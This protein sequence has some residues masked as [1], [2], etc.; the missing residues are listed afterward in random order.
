MNAFNEENMGASAQ[1][2]EVIGKVKTAACERCSQ[3]K[4]LVVRNPVP[5]VLGALVF[6]AAVGYL[7]YTRRDEATLY[8]RLARDTASVRKQLR[9]APDRLSEILHD[10]LDRASRKA[11]KAS[12]YVHDLPTDDVIDSVSNSLHRLANRLKFW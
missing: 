3:A 9:A 11:H 2:G 12:D 5:T 8:D 6:G 10:G 1:A 4:D 7:I